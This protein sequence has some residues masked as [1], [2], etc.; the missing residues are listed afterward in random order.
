M[1]TV[2]DLGVILLWLTP[3]AYG[4]GL[5]TA[6]AW[7]Y[8][9]AKRENP[10]IEFDWDYAKWQIIFG[11]IGLVPAVATAVSVSQIE[12]WAG[13]GVLGL[14]LAFSAGFGFARGGREAQKSREKT[15]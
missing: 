4:L 10:E 6:V 1:D 15:E 7:P 2:I 3:V 12:A 5:V 9:N 14:I 11:L 13:Q 8:L